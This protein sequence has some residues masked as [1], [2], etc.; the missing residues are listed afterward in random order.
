[1]VNVPGAIVEP[2]I[3]ASIVYVAVMQVL[4]IETRKKLLVVFA[5]GLLHGLGFAGAVTFPNGTPIL[6]ALIGFNVGIELGQAMIIAVVFPLLLAVRRFEW[7][8]LRAGRGGLRG[9]RYGPV[10]A[11]AARAGR[12]MPGLGRRQRQRLGEQQAEQRQRG[13]DP[14]HGLQARRRRRSRRGSRPRC[15]RRRSRTRA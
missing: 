1:M 5:F 6:S 12:L 7:A 3:A 11:V 8:R 14:H 4:G 15:R 13:D 2:L 10:L 9:R